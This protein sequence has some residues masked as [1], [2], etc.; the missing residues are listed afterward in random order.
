MFSLKR[1]LPFFST[2]PRL[3]TPNINNIIISNNLNI[4]NKFIRPYSSKSTTRLYSLASI[5][6]S[7]WRALGGNKNKFKRSQV[8]RRHLNTG[9]PRAH[10]RHLQMTKYSNRNQ[11]KKLKKLMPYG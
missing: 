3:K 1:A 7:S 8:G 4:I 9:V 5:S 2:I 11:T 10:L 6:T